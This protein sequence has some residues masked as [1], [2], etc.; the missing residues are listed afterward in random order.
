MQNFDAS[1]VFKAKMQPLLDELHKLAVENDIPYVAFAQYGLE[2]VPG[3]D[4]QSRAAIC[5]QVSI[6]AQRACPIMQAVAQASTDP[7]MASMML[8]SAAMGHK[9]TVDVAEDERRRGVSRDAVDTM[10]AKMAAAVTKPG[11]A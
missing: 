10:L 9:E 5:A 7:R 4:T 11:N 6:N 8:L 2:D 1:E 3:D